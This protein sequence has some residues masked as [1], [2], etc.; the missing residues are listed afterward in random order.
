MKNKG[1]RTRGGKFPTSSTVIHVFVTF[2]VITT[3]QRER[4][5]EREKRVVNLTHSKVKCISMCVSM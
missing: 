3:T 2:N 5:S 4:V 1:T